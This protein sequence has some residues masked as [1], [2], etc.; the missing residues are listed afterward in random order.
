M[1]FNVL[2]QIRLLILDLDYLVFDCAALKVKSLRESLIPFAESIPHD[3]RLPDV[4]DAEEG[5]RAHGRR[6][7]EN[8]QL[9]LDE[10]S[11]AR[12]QSGY[13][14]HEE[15]LIAAGVGRIY[16]G[17]PELLSHCRR[18]GASAAIGAEATRDYLMAVS[19][20]HDLDNIF[21]MVYCTEEFGRGDAEEM[22]D[23]IMDRAEVHRS[24]TL[25]LG[26]RTE[27]FVSARNLDI[28][29]IGC[30]WGLHDLTQLQEADL[31]S[32]SLSHAFPAIV[33]ADRLVAQNPR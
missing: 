18:N 32:P 10:D 26:T 25:L 15:K 14:T 30:G 16:P 21:E 13:R 12:F 33:E 11:I 17:L 27:F 20:R 22:F 1:D 6:W 9:G 8:L 4:V 5:F 19:D 2:G 28:V 3:V 23:E 29:S 31:Q 24:E 7:T